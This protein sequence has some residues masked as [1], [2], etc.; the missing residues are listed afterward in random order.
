MQVGLAVGTT[1][2]DTKKA[3]LTNIRLQVSICLILLVLCESPIDDVMKLLL[4]TLYVQVEYIVQLEKLPC[5][6]HLARFPQLIYSKGAKKSWFQSWR[7]KMRG[8]D[9]ETQAELAEELHESLQNSN[10]SD[11]HKVRTGEGAA[12]QVDIQ[13]FCL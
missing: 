12:V 9:Y 7:D 11:K 1:E 3:E 4:I 10:D 8:V 13:M 6:R 5:V 2:E